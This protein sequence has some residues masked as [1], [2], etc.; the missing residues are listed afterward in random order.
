MKFSH[1]LAAGF[2][3]ASAGAASAGCGGAVKFAP[4]MSS[5]TVKGSL[6]GYDSCDYTVAAKKGQTLSASV[7]GGNL[8]VIVISPVE[9][10]FAADGSLTLPQSGTYTVRVLQPRAMA[11]KGKDANFSLTVGVKGAKSSAAT[12][13]AASVATKSVKMAQAKGTQCEGSGMFSDGTANMSGRIAGDDICDY[14]FTGQKGQ[15]V[16]LMMDAKPGVEA[17]IT[18]PVEEYL[19]PDQAFV[20]PQ[21]GSYSLTIGRTRADAAK[22]GAKDFSAVLNIE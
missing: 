6:S 11:R 16:T 12:V 14:T 13:P 20:L 21:S 5:G 15:T 7:K 4:G 2:I 3:L 1:L 22:G 19:A 8:D 10:N 17:F 9:H 18:A